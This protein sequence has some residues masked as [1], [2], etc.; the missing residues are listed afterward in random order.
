MKKFKKPI[1]KNLTRGL[2]VRLENFVYLLN[3]I[4]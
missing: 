1:S 3:K 2:C 4:K